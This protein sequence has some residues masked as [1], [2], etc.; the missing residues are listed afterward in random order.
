MNILYKSMAERGRQWAEIIARR[1]PQA[2]FWQW[3]AVPDP[4]AVD[5]LVAWEASADLIASL[6]NLKVL[7]SVGA[8]ADQFDYAALPPSLPVARMVEP[9]IVNGM[10]EYV[11]FAVLGLHRDMPLYLQQQREQRWQGH[12]LVPAS[13]RRVG[14]MGL[15]E[16]GQAVITQLQTLGFACRGW[17]RTPKS[18][19]GVACFAG[20]AQRAAF[21]AD[22]DILVCL[23]PLT[24]TTHGMLNASLFDQLPAGAALV[25]VGRG[26]Q[27]D[28][29]DL[30][31]A[32]DSGRLR[33]A[34]VDV[35][36]PEPLP[37]THP[38]WSHPALW[39]T[40]HIASQTQA[41]SAVSALM[42]NIARFERG[43]PM[44]GVIDRQR[45]Y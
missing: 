39:L 40:P 5:Y 10:V 7:F 4:A 24:P 23:L 1:Y 16:L 6:P 2:R 21:L 42:D 26:A 41:D 13:Q 34:V 17:S 22:A 12:P 30:L 9:G 14:V 35:T 18:L 20:D 8:G 15:G 31:A 32:L 37:P 27:L 38:F 45:G 36:D 11:T 19:P 25:Q 43:E 44:V 28:H 3:P 33:G 29:E